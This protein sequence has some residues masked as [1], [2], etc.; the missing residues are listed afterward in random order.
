MSDSHRSLGKILLGFVVLCI[1]LQILGIYDFNKL[2]DENV[3]KNISYKSQAEKDADAKAVKAV[4][5]AKAAADAKAANDALV[6][7]SIDNANAQQTAWFFATNQNEELAMRDAIQN[8]RASRGYI[9]DP[10][11]L[12]RAATLADIQEQGNIAR[13]RITNPK[14]TTYADYQFGGQPISNSPGFIRNILNNVDDVA[15][16]CDS[17][18]QCRSFTCDD[19]NMNCTLMSEPMPTQLNENNMFSGYTTYSK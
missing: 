10:F 4:S 8:E 9:E 19:S 11:A 3:K 18:S 2:F 16:R 13:A 7:A 1:I 14:Y 6:K 15:S 12:A 5:D 17:D